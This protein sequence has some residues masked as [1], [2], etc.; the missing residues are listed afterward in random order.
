MGDESLHEYRKTLTDRF[1]GARMQLTFKE[2]VCSM[3]EQVPPAMWTTAPL[4]LYHRGTIFELTVSQMV[5]HPQSRGHSVRDGTG[6][7]LV[8]VHLKWT[9]SQNAADI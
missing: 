6:F 2:P 9:M 4:P 1:F 7:Y 8:T 3:D 5:P